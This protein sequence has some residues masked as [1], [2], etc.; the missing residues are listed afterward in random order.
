MMAQ[1]SQPVLDVDDVKVHYG[2][3]RAV[4]GVSFQVWPGE[5]VGI[6]GPNGSGKTTLVNAIT[7]LTHITDGDIR[8]DGETIKK[9]APPRIARLGVRR[10]FQAI[11]LLPDLTVVE[12]VMLGADDGGSPLDAAFRPLRAAKAQRRSRV[13]ALEALG[14]V[15]MVEY[16]ELLP[17]ALPYGFQRR[18]EIARALASS[19]QLL[20]LDEPV[21][22][23]NPREREE[24]SELLLNLRS[25]GLTQLLIEHD[26]GLVTRVSS[27]IV[28]VDF[29]KVIAT[30]DPVETIRDERVREAYLGRKNA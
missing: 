8:V 2:G 20:L 22:G 17:G 19:P 13:A 5:L 10:T 16:A 29:G 15:G 26:L 21:A 28:V 9:F 3:V 30:G 27:R 12:N 6:V 4:D 11:R 25:E 7:A 18:V 1:E 23:M 24:V 14:R